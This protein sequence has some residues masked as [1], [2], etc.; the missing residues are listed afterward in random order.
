ML[1]SFRSPGNSYENNVPT[2]EQVT[3]K[4]REVLKVTEKIDAAISVAVLSPGMM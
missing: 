1:K 2:K 3:V 4:P